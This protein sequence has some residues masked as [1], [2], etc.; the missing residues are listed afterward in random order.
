MAAAEVGPL[1]SRSQLDYALV[2]LIVAGGMLIPGTIP[3]II[4]AG[5]LRITSK[6][7]I[8]VGVP[9]GACAM[10]IYFAALLAFGT[11]LT[12]F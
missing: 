3:T 12:C 9:I 11:I 5:K 1:M 10:A 6:E 7:W 2:S 4:A 8:S